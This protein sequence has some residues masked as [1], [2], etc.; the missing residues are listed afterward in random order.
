VPTIQYFPTPGTEK[1]LG[2][3][4]REIPYNLG[5]AVA[6]FF[7]ALLCAACLLFAWGYR[8]GSRE[9][10]PPRPPEPQ[11]CQHGCVGECHECRALAAAWYGYPAD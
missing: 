9:A 11:R 1:P 3:A 2:D 5:S 10:Q 4:L 8:R 7:L 6:C